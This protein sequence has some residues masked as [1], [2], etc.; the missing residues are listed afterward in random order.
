MIKIYAIY[1]M[2]AQFYKPPF[3]QRSK[4]EAL[5]TFTQLAND[6]QTLVGMHPEDFA[7]YELGEFDDIKG[8]LHP[9]TPISLGK[10]VDYVHKGQVLPMEG[11][12]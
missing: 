12:A 1:D 11:N 9:E 8:T 6:K 2:K 5:R 4:G 10:A 7:L 3:Y